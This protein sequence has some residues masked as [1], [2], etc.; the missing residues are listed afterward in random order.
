MSNNPIDK[1]T[2]DGFTNTSKGLL[3]LF[4]IGVIKIFLGIEFT[5]ST[6]SI[7]WLPTVEIYNIKNLICLYWLLVAYTIHRYVIHNIDKFRN[8]LYDIFVFSLY[9]QNS[10]NRIIR[11]LFLPD[12]FDFLIKTYPTVGDS[13]ICISYF[14]NKE[15][16]VNPNFELLIFHSNAYRFKKI[17]IY[18]KEPDIKIENFIKKFK[19][20]KL[21]PNTN[22]SEQNGYFS[23]RMPLIF[24]AL[25]CFIYVKQLLK[26]KNLYDI[27]MPIILNI[28][29]FF[30]W[31]AMQYVG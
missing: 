7:P 20:K 9:E 4:T 17:E 31:C 24:T 28:L 25:L 1:I 30:Y 21:K 11:S 22:S 6:I 23:S 16:L 14:Q 10:K 2:D 5:S 18:I 12:Q 26:N 3:T 19:L 29:L 8:I 13:I 15:F 27:S